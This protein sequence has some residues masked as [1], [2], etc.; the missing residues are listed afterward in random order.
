MWLY[1]GRWLAAPILLCCLSGVF[2]ASCTAASL[3]PQHP[4]QA[5]AAGAANPAAVQTTEHDATN[6]PLT[7]RAALPDSVALVQTHQQ[8]L[9]S[10]ELPGRHTQQ[11][12]ALGAGVYAALAAAYGVLRT[13]VRPGAAIKWP[14]GELSDA[15]ERKLW[16]DA[17]GGGADGLGGSGVGGRPRRRRV[18][19]VYAKAAHLRQKH[20]VPEAISVCVAVSIGPTYK[21]Q[22]QNERKGA[23]ALA[24]R[25]AFLPPIISLSLSFVFSSLLA[26]V[27]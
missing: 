21:S 8:Q 12:T 15:D 7:P 17:S 4:P 11:A 2:P 16:M 10:P 5:A 26:R 20:G 9:S 6:T 23:A 24:I 14:Y 18:K 22:Q 3:Q 1:L 25:V 13:F 19:L 27:A